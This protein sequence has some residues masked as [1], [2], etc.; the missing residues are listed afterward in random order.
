MQINVG[1][2]DHII[3]SGGGLEEEYVFDQM[4]FHW[5]SEHTIN[6]RRYALELHMVHHD[7]RYTLREAL[8]V[9]NGIAVLG[10]LFHVSLYENEKLQ[11]ILN[12]VDDIA[13]TV[14]ATAPITGPLTAA[15]LLP[16]NRGSYFRYEGSLTTPSCMEAVVWTVFTQSMPLS[17][18]QLEALKLMRSS[19]GSELLHNYRQVQPLN[20]RPLI[21]ATDE[22]REENSAYVNNAGKGM[23]LTRL[24]VLLMATLVLVC[25]TL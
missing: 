15:D 17:L 16:H 23:Q 12:S 2:P 4:H 22:E 11:N 20:A 25:Y 14:G 1:A 3:L 10:V 19:N 13:S 8:S 9:K 6:G 5:G 18:D 7:R 21:Y 24:L